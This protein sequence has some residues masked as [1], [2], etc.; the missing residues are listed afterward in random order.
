MTITYQM[1]EYVIEF[2]SCNE[3]LRELAIEILHKTEG[4]KALF[5]YYQEFER[6][7]MQ[8]IGVKPRQSIQEL[9]MRLNK[10]K[11]K[12]IVY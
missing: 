4:K 10:K 12:H 7:L 11:E 2:N 1:L 9:Y 3:D 6:Q 5:E 8:Q